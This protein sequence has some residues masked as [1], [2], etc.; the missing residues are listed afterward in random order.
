MHH[1]F[2]AFVLLVMVPRASVLQLQDRRVAVKARGTRTY[3]EEFAAVYRCSRRVEFSNSST[4]TC[5]CK[6]VIAVFN[7]DHDKHCMQGEEDKC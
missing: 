6:C 4:Y 1:S 3:E 7:C 5:L 2:S